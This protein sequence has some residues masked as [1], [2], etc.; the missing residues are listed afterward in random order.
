[1]CK[2]LLVAVLVK[3]R[4][5]H[6][7]VVAHP[8]GD[9]ETDALHRADGLFPPLERIPR[10]LRVPKA[11]LDLTEFTGDEQHGLL[12]AGQPLRQLPVLLVLHRLHP[13]PSDLILESATLS[14]VRHALDLRGEHL[15]LLITASSRSR[16]AA[17]RMRFSRM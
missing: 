11:A 13:H 7:L 1:M 3:H 10:H 16:A 15:E 6:R 4:D 9:V 2:L 17:S 12:D 14:R 5:P 8:H